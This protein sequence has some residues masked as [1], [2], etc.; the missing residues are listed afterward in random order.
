MYKHME[1]ADLGKHCFL[2]H[3][4]GFP[5]QFQLSIMN[6]TQLHIRSLKLMTC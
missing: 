4:F 2:L 1:K 5:R 6:W 3:K